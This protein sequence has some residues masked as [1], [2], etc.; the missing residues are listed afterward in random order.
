[1]REDIIIANQ[2]P[3]C[4]RVH[5]VAVDFMD[6]MDWQD[7]KLAQDAF[8]Y[9][10]AEEREQLISGFCPDCIRS[11]FGAEEEED[12]GDDILVCELESVGWF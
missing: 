2:C 10:S 12:E 3:L 7:G 1:M 8:P 5:E 6:F 11:V 9:L 4:G